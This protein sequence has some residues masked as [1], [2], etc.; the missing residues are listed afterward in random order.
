[1]G[2][3]ISLAALWSPARRRELAEPFRLALH[4]GPGL[5]LPPKTR[6]PPIYLPQIF[7]EANPFALIR[8][9]PGVKGWEPSRAPEELDREG[10]GAAVISFERDNALALMP[11]LAA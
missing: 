10:V 11:S 8:S 6:S 7:T 1:M 9:L 2:V 4:R 3:S 5:G